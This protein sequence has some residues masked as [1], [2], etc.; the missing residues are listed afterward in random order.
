MV[1]V[2]APVLQLSEQ[3]QGQSL[4]LLAFGLGGCWSGYPE[5]TV[6]LAADRQAAMTLGGRIAVQEVGLADRWRG[7]SFDVE[8]VEGHVNETSIYRSR[9]RPEG[10]AMVDVH[11]QSK[12]AILAH[13]SNLMDGLQLPCLAF[14]HG[15]GVSCPEETGTPAR[16]ERMRG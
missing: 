6:F 15:E 2:A 5:A 7:L 1:D 11:W 12:V 9:L 4:W 14:G 10:R 8:L 3:S 13:W 16:R